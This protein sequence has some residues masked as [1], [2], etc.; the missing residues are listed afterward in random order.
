MTVAYITQGMH[1]DPH[2]P[3]D[4]LCDA[5]ADVVLSFPLPDVKRPPQPRQDDPERRRDR[6][7]HFDNPRVQA[8][9]TSSSDKEAIEWLR[10]NLPV[11]PVYFRDWESEGKV[12]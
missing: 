10:S 8:L 3:T 1:D 11:L 7:I 2:P 4:Q 6:L 5:M 9:I 12:V